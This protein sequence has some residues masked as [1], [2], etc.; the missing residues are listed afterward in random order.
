MAGLKAGANDYLTKPVLKEELLARIENLL[1]MKES[2][3]RLKEN[4]KLQEEISR[5]QQIELKLEGMQRQLVRILDAS[6]E[7]IIAFDPDFKITFFN[8]N[9][10]IL[11][12]YSFQELLGHSVSTIFPEMEKQLKSNGWQADTRWRLS[13]SATSSNPYRIIV[14]T[15]DPQEALPT[16]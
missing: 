3:K 10:E 11:F 2:I 6:P 14:K 9:A 4:I 15:E 16:V 8:Q 7:A 13:S 5:R 1:E 12:G